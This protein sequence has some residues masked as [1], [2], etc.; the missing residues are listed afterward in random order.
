MRGRVSGP[1]IWRYLHGCYR[2]RDLQ[3]HTGGCFC[4]V[5]LFAVLLAGVS[6][7]DTGRAHYP[8]PYLMP[9]VSLLGD[10]R[11]GYL[12]TRGNFSVMLKALRIMRGACVGGTRAH[13]AEVPRLRSAAC[14][15]AMAEKPLAP[16]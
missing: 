11:G 13:R 4:R 14:A 16:S 8:P 6:D 3:D 12:H 15:Q 7:S 2:D 5:S 10:R 1:A 9:G